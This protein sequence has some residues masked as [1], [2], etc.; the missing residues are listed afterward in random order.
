LSL[1][2]CEALSYGVP[3]IANNV[4]GLPEVASLLYSNSKELV[5]I[6]HKLINDVSY[7]NTLGI[8]AYERYKLN[9][10]ME[11]GVKKLRDIIVSLL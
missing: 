8:A 11:K 10:K 7:R 9:F 2:A 1:A 6:L 3:V 5:E 4:G